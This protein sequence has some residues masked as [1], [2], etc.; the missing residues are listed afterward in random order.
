MA[1][2]V[3]SR[4]LAP[5][6]YFPRAELLPLISNESLS[7]LCSPGSLLHRR[8]K[9]QEFKG[10]KAQEELMGYR[11]HRAEPI[12]HYRAFL[13]VQ[14]LRIHLAMQ[15]TPIWSLSGKIPQAT[16]QLSPHITS[17]EPSCC[18][19]WSPSTQ[20]LCPTRV[21]H[22]RPNWRKP[23]HNNKDPAQPR[24]NKWIFFLKYHCNSLENKKAGSSIPPQHL[25]KSKSSAILRRHY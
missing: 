20:S 21:A 3:V 12:K 6:Q 10:P 9:C 23:T 14:W 11:G 7:I 22:S 2:S 5:W 1:P 4:L 17:T 25:N 13:V 18:N 16:E 24:V 15:E 19:Y 8:S